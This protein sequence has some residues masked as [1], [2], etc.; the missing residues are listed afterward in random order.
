[1]TVA[2]NATGENAFCRF[3]LDISMGEGIMQMFA[4]QI[5][6]VICLIGFGHIFCA[7]DS[8]RTIQSKAILN[9]L[10]S[11]MRFLQFHFGNIN[12]SCHFIVT[13]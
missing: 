5:N 12:F 2:E 1:M 6:V 10:I 4:L 3:E 7:V 8:G 13:K 11:I 9:I